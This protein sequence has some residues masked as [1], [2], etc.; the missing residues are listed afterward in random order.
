MNILILHGWNLDRLKYKPLVQLLEQ[1]GHRVFVPDFPGFGSA[2]MP[3]RPYTL[4]DYVAFTLDYMKHHS[5]KNPLIIGHS[6]GGRVAILLTAQK[7]KI[8]R[9]LILTGVPGIRPV[10]SMKV[11]VFKFIAS[12]AN[13]VFSLPG[14]SVFSDVARKIL[15]RTTG[16]YDYY[17]TSGVMRETFRH[18][19]ETDLIEPMKQLIIPV[20]LI[21]GAD[22]R[23]TP[24]WIAHRMDTY[25]ADTDI[26]ILPEAGHS[27]CY[28]QPQKFIAIMNSI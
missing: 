15:Y 19:I 23:I 24:V 5:I 8:A 13:A 14:L 2:N 18:V 9:E 12:I 4:D 16:S 25:I 6:F 22:D 10:P 21:W 3:D 20:Q 28:Q 7:S 1:R 11:R 27:V 26:A 17:R